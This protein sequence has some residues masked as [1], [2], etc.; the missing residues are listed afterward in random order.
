MSKKSKNGDSLK[1]SQEGSVKGEALTGK[2]LSLEDKKSVSKGSEDKEASKES[3]D[4]EVSKE[5]KKSEEADSDKVVSSSDKEM[6][7]SDK[8]VGEGE[9]EGK[10]ET[11]SLRVSILKK[12][13]NSGL[14]G[15]IEDYETAKLFVE[16]NNLAVYFKVDLVSISK[17]NVVKQLMNG[18]SLAKDVDESVLI[19]NFLNEFGS[20]KEMDSEFYKKVSLLNPENRFNFSKDYLEEILSGIDVESDLVSQAVN[21]VRLEFKI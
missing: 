15:G 19:N 10:K 7:A 16:L 14:S 1:K 21:N 12:L 5:S 18:L 8:S 2:D 13:V 3:E 6:K 4:K 11:I 17:W 20:F 9:K